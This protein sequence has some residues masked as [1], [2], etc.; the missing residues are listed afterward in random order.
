VKWRA[1]CF[2]TLVAFTIGTSGAASV[3]APSTTTPGG[4][5]DDK[6]KSAREQVA[7]ASADEARLLEQIDAS[8]AR[9]KDLDKT[10][11]SLDAQVR[12]VQ[13]EVDAA[14][15]RLSAVEAEEAKA[16]QRLTETQAQLSEAKNQLAQQA[17]AAYTGQT[18]AIQFLDVTLKARDI[19]ELIAKREYIKAVTTSQRE[20]IALHERLRNEVEDRRQDLK[21][22]RTSAE[23]QRDVVAS[24]R[25]SLQ[26]Q[27][28]TQALAQSKVQAEIAEGGRLRDEALSRKKEFQAEVDALERESQEIAATLRA[29]GSSGGGGD[30]PATPSGS[31]RLVAPIPGAP[32]VSGFGPRVHPIYGDVRVHTGIDYAA[33]EGTAIHAAG[34]GIVIMAGSYGGY[35]NATIIDHGGGLATLYGHQS[36]IGVSEG[37]HV[38]QGQ[39]IGRVGCTGA[40]TGPHLHF[41]VRVNGTP[42]NPL[43]YL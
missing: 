2:A 30:S 17:I 4:S 29:R 12:S 41:E 20:L 35:G 37:E 19:G 3:A 32:I 27:L 13:S 6:L 28:D 11:S 1:L 8:A 38:S 23:E 16:E 39:V 21:K 10:V 25:S 31:G 34:D 7:E 40:C 33:S 24:K 18:E 15:S 14:Q 42:V 43:S 5:I 22:A 36:S 26:T 9:K